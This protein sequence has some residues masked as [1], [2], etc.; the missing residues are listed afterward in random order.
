MDDDPK[1]P[2]TIAH[3]SDLHLSDPGRLGWRETTPKRLLAY[4][5]WRRKRRFRHRRDVLERTVAHAKAARPDVIVV[6][7]DLTHLGLPREFREVR[8]WLPTLGSPERVLLVPGNHD[9]TSRAA[10]DATLGQWAPWFASD[11]QAPATA[12]FP[13]RRVVR[14]VAFIGVTT[15]RPSAPLLAV[16]RIGR[17]QLAAV[18]HLLETAGAAGHFRVVFL[19]HPPSAGTVRWRKRLTDAAALESVLARRG[20]E[21]ILHGHAHRASFSW[22]DAGAHRIPIIG[23]GSASEHRADGSREP[24][25]NLLRIDGP[26]GDWTLEATRTTWDRSLAAFVARD[27]VRISADADVRGALA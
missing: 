26:P 1:T 9:T 18:D 13:S 7:G 4:L 25:Y 14:G 8:A 16:G 21:L 17:R 2:L 19:H 20:A 24:E 10:F 5:S 23:V 22:L 3:L 12:P 11:P 6:T 15:A 27:P